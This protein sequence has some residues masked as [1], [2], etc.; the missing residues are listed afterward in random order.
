MLTVSLA[1]S[2]LATLLV[3]AALWPAWIRQVKFGLQSFPVGLVMFVLLCIWWAV[4][5]RR[6]KPKQL[7]T[8]EFLLA[9]WLL[10]VL[11]AVSYRTLPPLGGQVLATLILACSFLSTFPK[12]LAIKRVSYLALFPLTLP[13]ETALQ[14]VMGYP[15]RRISAEAVGVL[16]SPYGVTIEGTTLLYDKHPLEV[17][18]AC[19]GVL[20][21]WAF[22]IV[23][24]ILSI[25]LRYRWPRLLLTLAGGGVAS[26]AYNVLRTSLLFM[27]RFHAGEESSS[28][29]TLLG[30]VAFFVSITTF[31][32]IAARRVGPTAHI[33]EEYSPV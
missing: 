10:L 15:F 1:K 20:G 28:V 14:F 31:A 6:M 27:Y 32:M 12:E 8:G 5:Q 25:S 9:A 7:G 29:H 22:M 16:L 26:L 18:A 24:A 23:G 11:H 2:R 21:L 30:A 33:R 19:S 4:E 3:F 13:L 17:D